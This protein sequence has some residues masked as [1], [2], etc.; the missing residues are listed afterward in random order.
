MIRYQK[1]M[2]VLHMT[3]KH[4]VTWSTIYQ[5][6]LLKGSF[7][8]QYQGYDLV[9]SSMILL[10]WVSK[11]CSLAVAS[12]CNTLHTFMPTPLMNMPMLPVMPIFFKHR[13]TSICLQGLWN[14]K[15]IHAYVLPLSMLWAHLQLSLSI[16]GSCMADLWPFYIDNE[17]RQ[18]FWLYLMQ[19]GSHNSPAEQDLY[20][21]HNCQ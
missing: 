1:E 5:A 10:L 20:Q 3:Y 9:A 12:P 21:T 11:T 16:P 18:N 8:T 2:P 15:T 4:S 14:C 19:Y 7:L 6:N 13:Q 17:Y